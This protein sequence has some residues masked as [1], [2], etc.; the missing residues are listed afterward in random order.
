MAEQGRSANGIF[1]DL[2][3]KPDELSPGATVTLLALYHICNGYGLTSQ[4][5]GQQWQEGVQ[6]PATLESIAKCAGRSARTVQR[7]LQELE[8][9]RRIVTYKSGIK[10]DINRYGLLTKKDTHTT[11][12]SDVNT[13]PMSDT[14]EEDSTTPMSSNRKYNTSTKKE[15]DRNK[16]IFSRT[17]TRTHYAKIIENLQRIES[18]NVTGSDATVVLATQ[19]LADIRNR[20]PYIS[21]YLVFPKS[22][23]FRKWLIRKNYITTQ[24]SIR[25]YDTEGNENICYL[26]KACD[27]IEER[28]KQEEE[29]TLPSLNQGTLPL[30]KYTDKKRTLH[31]T[32][33]KFVERINH[34]TNH[35]KTR[36]N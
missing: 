33:T 16:S 32:I 22:E 7:D 18:V 13:T 31:G 17:I 19:L 5:K 29:H 25:L 20:Y 36:N 10:Y 2:I 4:L 35:A 11:P 23:T 30:S 28:I 6:F 14:N 27:Q 24:G 26:L 12:M 9:R 21:K 1:Y 8:E 15:I 34:L 3:G